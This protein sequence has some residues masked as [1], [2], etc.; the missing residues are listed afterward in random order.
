MRYYAD[1]VQIISV[2]SVYTAV[3]E[4]GSLGYE[5]EREPR[6]WGYFNPS[7]PPVSIAMLDSSSAAVFKCLRQT[8][9]TQ[10]VIRTT[11]SISTG[12]KMK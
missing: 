9:Q 8:Q 5:Q 2:D 3:Q 10:L 1:K 6:T 7:Q 12:G 11:A 4:H